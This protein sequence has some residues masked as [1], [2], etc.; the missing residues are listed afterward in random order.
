MA[1]VAVLQ[2]DT[3]AAND[4]FPSLGHNELTVRLG[5]LANDAQIALDRVAKG[6]DDVIDAWLAYGAALNEGRA[7]F[8][9]DEQFGQWVD[10]SVNDKL[11]VTPNLHERASAMWASAHPDQF[12]EARRAGNARTVRGVYAK[13]NEI[14]AERAADAARQAAEKARKDAKE[15][16]EAEADAKRKE[17]E[18]KGEAER[19]AALAAKAEAERAAARAEKEA[20]KAEKE[21]KKAEKKADKVKAGKAYNDNE[22]AAYRTS[23]TGKNEW[24]TPAR[25]IELART[26]MGQI[27][28]DPASNDHAQKTVRATS[29]YTEE[30]NGLDKQ[31]HGKVWMNPPYSQPDIV[32]FI[33]KVISEYESGR[34]TEA[35]VLTHNSTDTAWYNLIFKHAAAI[36]W[37]TGRVRFESP[38][39][40][41]AA[42]AM[43][44]TF[45]YFGDNPKKF[46][47]AFSEVGNVWGPQWR[48]VA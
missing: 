13:W 28:V 16:A 18:A 36:C 10:Q 41:K 42:P 20:K 6:E 7:L 37:T 30:T 24:Y 17:Q 11:S 3:I 34:C 48:D 1:E 25:Y 5:I 19:Q 29:F 32:H 26:V 31:W 15:K 22:P 38:E 23:F 33:E 40:E 14:D 12:A 44:Q 45:A 8:P 47:N 43:G 4:N 2:H 27:D 46:H 21:A 9:S 39:G 35:I